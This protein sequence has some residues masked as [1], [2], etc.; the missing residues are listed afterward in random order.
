MKRS[1]DDLENVR[2]VPKDVN[3]NP[4]FIYTPVRFAFRA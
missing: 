2:R 3:D 1:A 4:V